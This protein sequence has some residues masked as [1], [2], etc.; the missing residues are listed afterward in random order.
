MAEQ[1]D[2]IIIGGGPGGYVA[3]IRAA[4]LK[5]KVAL[6]EKEH[7]GG[8]CLNW[9]CIPTKALLKVSE[10]FHLMN[11]C[12][13]FGLKVKEVSF[14]M[15]KVVQYS[16]DVSEKLAKGVEIL[17][18]KNQVTV[19]KGF[20]KLLGSGKVSI[21]GTQ[22]ETIAGKNIIIATGAR[23]R[24]IPALKIDGEFIW[25]YKHA[26]VPK[27]LPKKLLVVGSGAIGAEFA[28]FYHLM[29]SDVTIC[30]VADRILQSED[31]DISQ[32]AH[33]CFEKRG[34]K[35][36]TKTEVLGT[37]ISGKQVE[38][39]IR[40]SDG[41]TVTEKFDKIISAVGIVA[42][43][44]NIGLEKT[45]VK[46]EKGIVS[47]DGYLRTAEPNVYAVGDI[48]SAP[49]LAH[50]A[51]HEAIIAVEHIACLKPHVMNFNNIP[52]CTY[53]LPQIASI[54]L[55]EAKAKEKGHTL[56]VGK[57]PLYANGK[58]IAINET[59]GFV[60]TIFDAKTG[61]ILGVH[62]IGAE[63][64]EMIQ[65][66][67]IAK[68]LEATEVELMHTIFPHPTVSET[69]HESVLDAFGKAVHM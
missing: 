18:K 60:K 54:G 50:K 16:R 7:L 25:N 15:K 57:F 35:I 5:L 13:V 2:V 29:G 12:E 4:Q 55:T 42:N 52:A 27:E 38:A 43:L 10:L 48:A 65:G 68:T 40:G 26:L 64:T 66:L 19:F 31:S 63:V 67:A 8:I 22:N 59:D 11:S 44:E 28:S 1:F 6:I 56:K 30:E 62:M 61:E 39:K 49:W 32:F 14:D 20:G 21:E 34:I 37:S 17:M 58:A 9:G 33:K 47:V 3:A 23:P 51:S 41:K 24:E 69:I 46:V 36:L 53:T 45:K